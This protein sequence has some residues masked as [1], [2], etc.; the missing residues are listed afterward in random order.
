MVQRP[1]KT[2]ILSRTR[3]VVVKVGSGT[4]SSTDGIRRESVAHLVRGLGTLHAAGREVVLVTSGAV[5]A[6][7][8]THNSRPAAAARGSAAAHRRAAGPVPR[9]EQG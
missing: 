6:G 8:P 4:L 3:R 7:R 1:H 9:D 5:A 2:R